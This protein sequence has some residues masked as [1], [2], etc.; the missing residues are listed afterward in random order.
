MRSRIP[1]FR[2]IA[3]FL[4]AICLT[5]QAA[6][7]AFAEESGRQTVKVAVLNHSIY[8]N[9]DASGAWRGLDVECMSSR[10]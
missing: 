7:P 10:R 5:A 6:F 4:A 8:A 1:A 3:C 9:Q 2:I